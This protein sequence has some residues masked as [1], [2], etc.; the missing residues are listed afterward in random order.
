[1]DFLK[2]GFRGL[3]D[4]DITMGVIFSYIT[5]F[6]L[7]TIAISVSIYAIIPHKDFDCVEDNNIDSKNNNKCPKKRH[8]VLL[9][10]LFLIPFS[11]LIIYIA[12]ITKDKMDNNPDMETMVGAESAVVDTWQALRRSSHS[13]DE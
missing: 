12:R 13:P 1:M 11:I 8:Y 6:I 7:I 5:A 4:Y 10:V 9:F 2:S 3:G